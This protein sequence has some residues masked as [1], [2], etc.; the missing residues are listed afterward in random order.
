MLW[1]STMSLF[2]LTKAYRALPKPYSVKRQT[3]PKKALIFKTSRYR[4]YL[5]PCQRLG[6]RA[7]KNCTRAIPARFPI[8]DQPRVVQTRS[9][10]ACMNK[11]LPSVLSSW[12]A[13]LGLSLYLSSNSIRFFVRFVLCSR[14]GLSN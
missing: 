3:V 7:S 14:S 13:I 11:R 1:L 8:T 10:L 6:G 5:G 12:K 4:M 9:R 2:A